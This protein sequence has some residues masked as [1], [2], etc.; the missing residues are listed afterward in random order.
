[1]LREPQTERLQKVLADG[2][3]YAKNL[4]GADLQNCDLHK[5]FLGKRHIDDRLQLDLSDADLYRATCDGASLRG[6]IAKGAV[7][8]KATLRGT[9]FEWADLRNANFELANLDGAKFA[10][11]QIGGARFEGAANIPLEVNALLDKDLI[12][13]QE[14]L[15]PGMT[16][17][18]RSRIWHRWRASVREGA[19]RWRRQ[20]L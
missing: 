11:A 13:R 12:A 18:K 15:V 17:S 7:F 20:F 3:R 1:M 6:V 5:A 14:A 8:R 2:L 19:S 16:P 10:G 4:K 9:V